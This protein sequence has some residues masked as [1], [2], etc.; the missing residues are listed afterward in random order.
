MHA[1]NRR[2]VTARERT[3]IHGMYVPALNAVPTVDGKPKPFT[4]YKAR[5]A[6]EC[7]AHKQVY[8]GGDSYMEQFYIGL[9]GE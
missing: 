7:L 8:F 2:G 9:V 4:L 1:V 3:K 6:R 5:E